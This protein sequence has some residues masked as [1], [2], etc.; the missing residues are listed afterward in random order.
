[1]KEGE[2]FI[3]TG[4]FKSE[5]GKRLSKTFEKRL[6]GDYSFASQVDEMTTKEVLGWAK[7]FVKKI[8]DYLTRERYIPQ[9]KVNK[10]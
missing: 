9:K 6:I 8:K 10:E 1:M 3:K 2:H 4:L 5:M 7:E